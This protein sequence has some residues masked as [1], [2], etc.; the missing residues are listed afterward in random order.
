MDY[1]RDAMS[2]QNAILDSIMA[3]TELPRVPAFFVCDCRNG[4]PR[5]YPEWNDPFRPLSPATYNRE[6]RVI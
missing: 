6:N 4:C 2:E 5:C 1:D 3:G